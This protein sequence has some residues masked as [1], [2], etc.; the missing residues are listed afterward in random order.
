MGCE[1]G[2]ESTQNWFLWKGI[3]FRNSQILNVLGIPKA[4]LQ[5]TVSALALSYMLRA[6]SLGRLRSRLGCL[7]ASVSPGGTSAPAGQ[8]PSG[9]LLERL[10]PE[11]RRPLT[12]PGAAAKEERRGQKP[13]CLRKEATG[14]C[15]AGVAVHCQAGLWGGEGRCRRGCDG[16]HPEAP[17][18][19]EARGPAPALHP[20]ARWLVAQQ[21]VFTWHC[22]VTRGLCLPLARGVAHRGSGLEPFIVLRSFRLHW[23]PRS[24]PP[25]LQRLPGPWI[26]ESRSL[27]KSGV[28]LLRP[29][30]PALP[31]RGA[32]GGCDAK[33]WGLAS[34]TERSSPSLR[35]R[36]FAPSGLE[37]FG[38]RSPWCLPRL[39][40]G[41]S[42]GPDRGCA[43]FAS[44]RAPRT[45][46]SASGCHRVGRGWES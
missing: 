18:S 27:G 26:T 45:P 19:F 20:G 2:L 31:G 33:S 23:R 42:G 12:T 34:E 30:A 28:P 7:D 38:P 40:P 37:G 24:S 4:S 36:G 46:R 3:S 41:S 16:P 43:I 22:A 1:K 13:G 15:A 8:S 39:K 17:R 25:G 29:L 10:R 35:S 44:S 14:S 5:N 21:A 32:R 11:P 9:T 6:G